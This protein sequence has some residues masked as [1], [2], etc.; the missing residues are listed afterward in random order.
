MTKLTEKVFMNDNCPEWAKYAAVD[1]SGIAYWYA[2]EPNCNIKNACWTVNYHGQHYEKISD[3]EY[4][5]VDW[6]N[7][8]VKRLTEKL[9]KN[10]FKRKDCPSWAKYAAVEPNG[11][12]KWFNKKPD[13]D[14]VFEKYFWQ[15]SQDCFYEFIPGYFDA[16]DW[17]KSLIENDNCE[18][19][20][21]LNEKVFKIQTKFGLAKYAAV[22]K[23]G[24]GYLFKDKPVISK[25]RWKASGNCKYIGKFD[26]VNW[27]KSLI[28]A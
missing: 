24:D 13:I 22:D 25:D 16:A 2:E 1:K 20:E 10:V 23:N 3:E 12:A 14:F 4:D 18:I 21:K 7:S 15:T 19:K 5:S 6:M 8:L 28:K 11:K 17:R 9:N 26:N 27:E